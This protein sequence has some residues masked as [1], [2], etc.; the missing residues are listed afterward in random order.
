[1]TLF[2]VHVRGVGRVAVK[3]ESVTQLGSWLTVWS[4]RMDGDQPVPV[5]RFR[6]SEVIAWGVVC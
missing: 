6:T 4:G 2:A 3:G 5:A 1:M